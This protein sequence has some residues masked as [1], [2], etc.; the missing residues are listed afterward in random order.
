MSQFNLPFHSKS[1][2]TS[3]KQLDLYDNYLSGD[4]RLSDKLSTLTNLE[5]LGVIHCSLKELPDGYVS[6]N[7]LLLLLYE[8]FNTV[9][10]LQHSHVLNLHKQACMHHF[11]SSVV[12]LR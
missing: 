10:D 6:D 9:I 5:M 4:E 8:L 1:K 11:S 3:L 12:Y 7:V 2:M